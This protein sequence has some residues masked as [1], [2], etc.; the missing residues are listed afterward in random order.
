MSS[1]DVNIEKSKLFQ[2]Y[3]YI[4]TTLLIIEKTKVTPS[5]QPKQKK[6]LVN[7]WTDDYFFVHFVD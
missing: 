2:K 6:I 5:L 3:T 4:K 7:S 1:S